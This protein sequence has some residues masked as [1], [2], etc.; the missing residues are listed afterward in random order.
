ML[1]RRRICSETR[2]SIRLPIYLSAFC[3]FGTK[4]KDLHP[5]PVTCPPARTQS[6][7]FFPTPALLLKRS[8]LACSTFLA[9]NAVGNPEFIVA[10]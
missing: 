5:L 4:V 6:N 2:T 3:L 10:F 8:M 1:F 7:P 9:T